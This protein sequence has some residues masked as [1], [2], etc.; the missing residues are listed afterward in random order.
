MRDIDYRWKLGWGGR[1][2]KWLDY[3]APFLGAVTLEVVHWYG[4]RGKLALARYK[5]LLKSTE[6]WV[7]TAAMTVVGGLGSLILADGKLD[8]GRLLVLGAAFPTLFKELVSSAQAG[9]G[10]KLGDDETP[11]IVR[12]YFS[13]GR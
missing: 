11:S 9:A 1:D 6:Y 3:A 7:I 2:V 8:A 13:P 5:R 4:L 10:P 12:D